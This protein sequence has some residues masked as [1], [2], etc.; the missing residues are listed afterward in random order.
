MLCPTTGT[1]TLDLPVD[2]PDFFPNPLLPILNFVF[3]YFNFSA[4]ILGVQELDCQEHILFLNTKGLSI[5]N[6]DAIVSLS[7]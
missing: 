4:N 5:E 2:L 1:K 3:K 7:G 6:K